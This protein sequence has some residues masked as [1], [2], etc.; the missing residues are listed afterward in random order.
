MRSLLEG[1]Y[2]LLKVL[3]TLLMGLMIVPVT[4]Q[5]LSRFVDAI[6]RYIWTEEVARFCFV[7]MIMIG[8]VIAVKEG[9]H[10]NVDL[11]PSP[12][13]RRGKAFFGL[14]THAAMAL[15][16][17]VFAWHGWEFARFGFKQTSEMS[18][19]NMVSIYVSFPVAGL[20]WMLFLLDRLA[21][22]LAIVLKPE[23]REPS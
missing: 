19:I 5:I 11:L 18:G 23:Q 10:F 1:Y 20:S 13:T 22:D 12:R 17:V 6:P 7:W 3:L 8:S 14:L 9:T 4:L 2:R 21:V 16:A 15:M